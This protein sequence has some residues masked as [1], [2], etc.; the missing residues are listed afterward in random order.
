MPQRMVMAENRQVIHQ[1]RRAVGKDLDVEGLALV[2]C[3]GGTDSLALAA[4][5]AFHHRARSGRLAA[6]RVGGVVVDHGLQRGSA[7]AAERAGEQL[8]ELGLDPVMVIRA[9][10]D[11]ES[12]AGPEAAAR[13]ARYAAFSQA[14]AETGAS[15]VL[16]AHTKDDQAEQ[17]LLGLARGSGTRSLAGIP[18]RRGPF[19]RPLLD[20]SRSDTEAICAHEGLV[21]WQDPANADQRYLRSRIRTEIMPFLQSRLSATIT[22]SLART[23]QIAADDAAYLEQQA[24]AAFS[25]LLQ[26]PD[27]AGRLSFSQADL[28]A[29]PPA[30][31]RRVIAL[32]IVAVGGTNPASERLQAVDALLHGSASAG[33]IELEGHVR[34]FR[35]TRNSADY[36]KLVLVP[37]PNPR[38]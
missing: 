9:E 14:L 7:E 15:R 8:T 35:G 1:A 28:S 26:D 2:G 5:S 25:R 37:P 3:S 23:A 29:E 18:R 17:V 33:P 24:R 16:L 6:A 4:A 30:I 38:S 34:A 11:A 21:P 27:E 19:Y 20:L 36:G 10:V 31:R 32:G 13:S 22:D 12:S